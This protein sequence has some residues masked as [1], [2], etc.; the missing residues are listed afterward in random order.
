MNCLAY[1]ITF[2]TYGSWLPGDE[3]GFV[4]HARQGHSA[5]Q[6]DAH[7][8]LHRVMKTQRKHEAPVLDE[9]CRRVVEGAIYEICEDREWMLHALAVRTNHVHVVIS[10]HDSPERVLMTLKARATYHLR[11]R[12]QWSSETT[13]WARHGSTRYLNDQSALQA[14]CQYV[15]EGQG[16]D[17]PV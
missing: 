8:G 17:I 1:L 9:E 12:K 5:T 7:S 6:R 15:V 3:R 13:L 2:R 10:A 14:A 11:T 16:D 4:E